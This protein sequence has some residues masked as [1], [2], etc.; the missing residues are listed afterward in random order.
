MADAAVVIMFGHNQGIEQPHSQGLSS[1]PLLNEV[2][3]D[4]KSSDNTHKTNCKADRTAKKGNNFILLSCPISLAIGFLFYSTLLI[5]IYTKI[6]L[7][8]AT[9][10][11][12]GPCIELPDNTHVGFRITWKG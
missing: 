3:V 10:C 9:V 1:L 8:L 2:G 6:R 4:S 12:S 11:P 5:L 7:H